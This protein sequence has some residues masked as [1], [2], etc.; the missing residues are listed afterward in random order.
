MNGICECG[1][2]EKTNPVYRNFISE[3]YRK[4]EYR[5][6]LQGHNMGKKERIKKGKYWVVKCTNH[7]RVDEKG[8]VFEHILILEKSLGRF[9][10]IK[11]RGHHANGD[12]L[13]NENDN[14]VLCEDQKYHTL[15]HSRMKAFKEC[16]N[17]HLRKCYIC[18]KWDD[19]NNLYMKPDGCSPRHKS[20]MS[21]YNKL[22]RRSDNENSIIGYPLA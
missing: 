7:P 10:P 12:R 17:P 20:C 11:A 1:C 21:E 3:G 4:G 16:G 13:N 5:K 22:H 9:L 19:P 8:Y 14:L 18:Q 6:F 15:L 2:G